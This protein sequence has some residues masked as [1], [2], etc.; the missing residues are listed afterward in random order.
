[1]I[2]CATIILEVAEDQLAHSVSRLATP[3]ALAPGVRTSA[4]IPGLAWVPF[5]NKFVRHFTGI[6]KFRI[7]EVDV[8][9]GLTDYEEFTERS[10]VLFFNQWYYYHRFIYI[11]TS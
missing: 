6:V 7:P 8:E 10:R 9:R 2:Y 11:F 1:M 5:V 4:Q 3:H